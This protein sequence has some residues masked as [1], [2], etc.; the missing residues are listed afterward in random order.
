VPRNVLL[1]VSIDSVGVARLPQVLAAA[2]CRV[3]VVSGPGLAVTASRHVAKH[4]TTGRSPA[5][6]RQGMEQHVERFPDLYS[7]GLI[8]DEPLLRTFLSSPAVPALARLAP[9][10]GNPLQLARILSKVSFTIDMESAGIAV[11]RFRVISEND[12]LRGSW[13]HATSVMKTEDSLSGSGVRVIHNEE[14]LDAANTE[15]ISRPLLAQEYEAG[16]V[17]ATAVLFDNGEPRCWFSYFLSR[18]WPHAYAAASALEM[19]WHPEIESILAKLGRLTNFH[20]LCGIDW[21]LHEETGTPL[22]LE[23]NPRPTPGI[24]ASGMA[25]VD[26]SQ[27]IALWLSGDRIVQ[28]PVENAAGLYRMFPQNLYRAIDDHDLVEFCRTWRD[29]PLTDPAL[30]LSQLRRVATHYLPGHWRRALKRQFR[31]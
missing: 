2:G 27:A 10:T 16:R 18:N 25:G 17:G 8:A 24:Y 19:F 9:L 7:S 12:R 26:F 6:V 28:R 3:T 31:R 11:P 13:R 29:A 4:I 1:A 20:G 21:V 22:I 23:M 14:E 15:L 5:D 30:L